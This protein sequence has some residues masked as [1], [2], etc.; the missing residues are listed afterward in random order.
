[1]DTKICSMCNIEKHINNFYIN[2]SECRDCN[3]S[4]GLKRYYENK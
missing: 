2:F 3:R 4:R 1:M